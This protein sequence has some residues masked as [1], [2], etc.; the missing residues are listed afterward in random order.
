MADIKHTP[1]RRRHYL[2]MF[3]RRSGPARPVLQI[4]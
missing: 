3:T 2:D 4:E 1:L